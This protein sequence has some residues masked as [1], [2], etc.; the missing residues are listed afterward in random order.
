M[1]KRWTRRGRRSGAR[2]LHTWQ[3]L[4]I[5]GSGWSASRV[6]SLSHRTQIGFH[7]RSV[8]L[9]VGGAFVVSGAAPLVAQPPAVSAEVR[10]VRYDVTFD[11]AAAA[12][13]RVKVATSF[14]VAGT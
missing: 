1:Q 14:V 4:W 10:D 3:E 13:R 9:I 7:M 6:F 11:H 12:Q 8:R 5:C 2:D